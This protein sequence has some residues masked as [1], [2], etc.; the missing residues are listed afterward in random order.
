MVTGPW[1]S[2]MF[3]NRAHGLLS[4]MIGG[5]PRIGLFLI[6]LLLSIFF[7]TTTSFAEKIS[8]RWAILADSTEGMR[9]LD[10]TGS[11]IVFSGT[12]LQFYIE[13]LNN[14]HVYLFL[15]DSSDNLT[16]I[17]PPQRGY[18]DY[19]FPR[20]PKLVPPGDQ[21]FTFVPPPGTETLLLVASVERLF[22]LEKL[23]E[24]FNQNPDQ[25]GQQVLLLQEIEDM[26]AGND[27]KSRS[28]ER[29]EKVEVR[30]SSADGIKEKRFKAIKV[31]SSDFYG[32]KLLIDHR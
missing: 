14:C 26:F 6:A 23:T 8:F 19:G 3:N 15:L 20:G 32:R 16:P 12:A 10:F 7:T 25:M 31:K 30:Y 5:G 21:S 11:P 4:A 9:A 2:R 17:Y 29:M 1:L 28:A 18:Y 27:T 22:Q 13:H 24:V